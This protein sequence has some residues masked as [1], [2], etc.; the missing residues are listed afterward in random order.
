MWLHSHTPPTGHLAHN[1]GMCPDW[2]LN[3]QP[4]ASQSDAQSP[5][6]HQPEP[7]VLILTYQII[8]DLTINFDLCQSFCSTILNSIS[9]KKT[10]PLNLFLSVFLYYLLFSLKYFPVHILFFSN[11]L[12]QF[13]FL[14]LGYL[15]FLF[16]R[17]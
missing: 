10:D 1:P 8:L 12:Q 15:V 13:L 4:F 16:Y 3:L 5:E 2:K 11:A 17:L 6:P 7:S 9:L 14:C